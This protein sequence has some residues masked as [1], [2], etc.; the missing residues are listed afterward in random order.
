MVKNAKGERSVRLL[1]VGETVRHALSDILSRDIVQ[2]PDLTG[3]SITVCEVQVS[4]DLRNAT[5]FF[6][7]LGGENRKEVEA[8]LN[9]TSGFIRGLLSKTIHLKYMPKLKFELD[10]SFDEASRISA[11]LEDEKIKRDLKDPTDDQ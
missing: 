8:A 3:V 10:R 2:D 6:L 1:R 5:V 11:L 4:P 7:P 9:K